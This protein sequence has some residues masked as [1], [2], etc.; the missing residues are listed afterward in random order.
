[1]P[2]KK[3]MLVCVTFTFCCSTYFLYAYMTRDMLTN[4]IARGGHSGSY[5]YVPRGHPDSKDLNIRRAKAL[6]FE[7]ISEEEKDKFRDLMKIFSEKV[8]KNVTY[9]MYAGALLGSYSHHG[10]IPWDDDMDIIVSNNDRPA[11]LKSL[12]SLPPEYEHYTGWNTTW[13]FYHKNSPKAAKKPWNWPFVDIF[14]YV[15][16]PTYIQDAREAKKKFNKSV[17]FPLTTRPFMGMMLPAPRKTRDFLKTTYDI[18]MCVS[19]SYDHRMETDVPSYCRARVPCYLLQDRFPFVVRKN[20]ENK[21]L[22]T[23][24][25]RYHNIYNKDVYAQESA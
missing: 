14:F 1:M 4:C 17:V 23:L 21:S 24:E 3:G 10:L 20:S 22:E 5:G 2:S 7:R 18:D 25:D 13:K 19:N 16:Y 15:E 6:F 9:F 11:L 12:Q 8:S